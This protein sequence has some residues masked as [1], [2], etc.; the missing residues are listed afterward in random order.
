MTLIHTM[1]FAGSVAVIFYMLTYVFTKRYLSIVWHKVYLTIAIFLFLIPF[2]YFNINYGAWIRGVLGLENFYRDES[3]LINLSSRFIYVFNGS[4]YAKNIWL[5][6]FIAICILVSVCIL[7]RM[8]RRYRRMQKGIEEC[9]SLN[10]DATAIISELSKQT[11]VK[12]YLCS[13]LETP[14]AVGILHGKVILPDTELTEDRLKAALNHELIHIKVRDNLVKMFLFT[15]VI[16]NFYNPLV[17]Y[18]LS[19]WNTTAE[20]YCD[21]RALAGKSEQEINDYAN[22]IIDFAVGRHSGKLPFMGLAKS[23][24]EQQLKERIMHMKKT[25]KNYGKIGKALGTLLIVIGVFSSSLTAAAYRPRHVV[26]HYEEEFS[27]NEI[28]SFFIEGDGMYMNEEY[29]W[30]WEYE[31][32]ITGD[33]IMVFIDEEGGVHYYNDIE[34]YYENYAI[35]N[36]TYVNGN[37]IEHKKMLDGSCKVDYY[38]GDICSICENVINKQHL[39]THLYDVCPH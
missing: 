32:Y 6:I 31:Q 5:Y 9:S 2:Q 13:G 17:Y 39:S 26:M 27:G 22:M 18:L 35:C 29:M 12:A 4:I 21:D 8:V 23:A 14:V 1:G 11:G 7:F 37:L 16:L 20:L 3:G 10:E 30:L 25:R 36:H 15:V 28:E 19:R 33:Y 38:S 24:S 34:D